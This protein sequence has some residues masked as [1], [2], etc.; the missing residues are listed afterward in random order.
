MTDGRDAASRLL[1][2]RA[3]SLPD[4]TLGRHLP[5]G[6]LVRVRLREQVEALLEAELTIRAG[7]EHGVHDARVACRRLRSA[8]ATFAP[9][10]RPEASRPLNEELRWLGRSLGDARDLDVARERLLALAE[11]YAGDAEDAGPLIERVRA[12]D[13]SHRHGNRGGLEV[14]DSGRYDHLLDA[15]EAVV[16]DPPWTPDADEGADPFLRRRIRK[17]WRALASLVALVADVEPGGAPDEPLHDIRKA[18]KRLRYALEVAQ[19]LWPRKPRRLRKRIQRLTDILGERQ[20]TVLSRAALRE[21]ATQAETA[22]LPTHI[23]SRIL[24]MEDAHAAE[25]EAQFQREWSAAVE[26]RHT[27][28]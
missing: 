7:R 19:V 5:A 24:Q 13:W 11:R 6:R 16:V 23:H 22:G 15:L 1:D 14:L 12:E 17:E 3:V 27:W 21:L 28:P 20:D 26:R 4:E 9:V 18:A 8:L 25:L 10:I 2:I